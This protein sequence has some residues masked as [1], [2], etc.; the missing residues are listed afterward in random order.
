MCNTTAATILRDQLR[1]SLVLWQFAGQVHTL[2]VGLDSL[3]GAE[4]FQDGTVSSSFKSKKGLDEFFSFRYGHTL[5]S[6]EYIVNKGLG[7]ME[8]GDLLL[9]IFLLAIMELK[10]VSSR[11]PASTAPLSTSAAV[12]LW[13]PLNRTLSSVLELIPASVSSR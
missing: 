5:T 6:Y 4:D 12:T 1:T 10:T 8:T 13:L 11:A 9:S 3:F 7:S 2:I